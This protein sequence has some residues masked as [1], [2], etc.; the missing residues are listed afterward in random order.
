MPFDHQNPSSGRDLTPARVSDLGNSGVRAV[1]DKSGWAVESMRRKIIWLSWMRIATLVVLATASI[2]FS[3]GETTSFLSMVRRMLLWVSLVWL[4]PSSLYFPILIAVKSRRWLGA[5]A[6]LQVLQDSLFSAVMVAVTGGSG[7]AFT[8]FFSLTVVISGIVVGRRGTF[9]LVIMSS[10]LLGVIAMFE[11]GVFPIPYFMTELL[12]RSSFSSVMYSVALNVV[13][14][15][16]IGVLSSYLAE[17]LRRADIQRER[18]RT[19]LEDLRQLHASIVSSI[20]TGIVT[21]RLDDRVLHVNRAAETLLDIE[22]FSANGRKLAEIMPEF[23]EPLDGHYGDFE[24]VRETDAGLNRYLQVSVSPLMS[25]VG[26]MMGRILVVR[27]VT[28]VKEMEARMKADERL[29][30]IGKLSS[31]VAH[32]IRNPLAAISASAQMISMTGDRAAGEQRALD[33]VVQETDRLNSFITDLLDYARPRKNTPFLVDLKELV[34][35]VLDVVR[36]DPATNTMEV[37]GD[38]RPGLVIKGDS[39]RLHRVFMNLAKN[40]IEAMSDG[41]QLLIRG[42]E[43]VSANGHWAVLRVIDNGPGIP[44]DERERIFDAFYTTK[45]RGT[46]LGL[47]TVAQVVE[48][49][50]GT[51]SVISVHDVRTEFTVKLPM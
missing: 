41:G 8:F 45:P 4:V 26:E 37:V 23:R 50:G 51:V 10:F 32:E 38:I 21:C 2:A 33:I 19:N 43:E 24:I 35:Q 39:Q 20:D 27:D 1:T 31:V 29:A 44:E 7:S 11:V 18:Y 42:R 48:E 16:S 3:G 15:V 40:A 5:V 30:T 22:M 25:S 36:E 9:I 34:E 17:A 46:G 28:T 13:A 14:F 47:A 6:L 49:H 12:V